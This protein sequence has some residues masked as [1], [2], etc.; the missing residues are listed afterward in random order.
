M[1]IQKN[2]ETSNTLIPS[3]N[4]MTKQYIGHTTKELFIEK[5]DELFELCLEHGDLTPDSKVLDIG[6]GLGRLTRP[7]TQYL[8]KSGEY[9]GMDVAKDSIDWCK[10]Q[11][12]GHYPNFK[13]I[14]RDL[15]NKSYNPDGTNKSLLYKFPFDDSSLD[16]VILFSVFTH[17]Y[18]KDI[19][20][21]IQEL[22][23]VLKPG[24][25]CII[26]WYL[27]NDQSLSSIHAGNC[28]NDIIEEF[29]YE[30]PGGLTTRKNEPEYCMA[31]REDL[32][33]KLYER[34]ALIIQEPIRYG[35]W[36]G[37]EDGFR[38]QEF[39]FAIKGD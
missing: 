2:E 28:R 36:S 38:F 20:N 39:V 30:I 5:G 23:R 19:E 26:T 24:K 32:V 22:G 4:L 1:S 9:Y 17:M 34:E 27:L 15:Y 33:R 14:W 11:Y 31:Y 10:E 8:S 13:F 37:R 12:G 7:F 6:C 18:M 29:K 25:K 16:C 3:E 35:A 21:Y